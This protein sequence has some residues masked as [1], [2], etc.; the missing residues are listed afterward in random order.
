MF[1]KKNNQSFGMEERANKRKKRIKSITDRTDKLLIKYLP[2][3]FVEQPNISEIIYNLKISQLKEA[4]KSKF[5]TLSEYKYAHNLVSQFIN[6]GN[7]EGKWLL[8]VPPYLIRYKRES[9]LRTLK[10]FNN[11][12]L[13][14]L[15]NAKFKNAIF[16]NKEISTLS[17]DQILGV[18]LISAAING[19]LCIQSGLASLCQQLHD[20]Q[21]LFQQQADWFWIDLYY[22]S[23]H[24]V[25]Y[26]INDEDKSLRR[27]YPDSVTLSLIYF[28]LIKRKSGEIERES[29]AFTDVTCWNLIHPLLK[30]YYKPAS[31]KLLMSSFCKAAIGLVEQQDKV[32]LSQANLHHMIGIVASSSLTPQGQLSLFQSFNIKQSHYKFSDL[33]KIPQGRERATQKNIKHDKIV[34]FEHLIKKI[35]DAI[36]IYKDKRIKGGEFKLNTSSNA[37]KKLRNI[38]AIDLP[39]NVR[40]ITLWLFYLLDVKNLKI[41]TLRT[42]FSSIG[43]KWLS[44][45]VDVE[46]NLFDESDF[47]ELYES[48]LDVETSEKSKCYCSSRLR[49]FHIFAT[50]EL[51]F[52]ALSQ[53]LPYSKN[54]RTYVR[55]GFINELTFKLLLQSVSYIEDLQELTKQGLKC[56]LIIAY[57]AGLRRG[58]LIKLKFFD[59]EDSD[60][61]WVFIRNNK[62]GTNKSGSALRKIPLAV[63]LLDTEIEILDKYLAARRL[64]INAQTNALLFSM[65]AANEIPLEANKIS[66]MVKYLLKA[67]T[68]DLPFTFHHLR[69]SALSKLH[70][71]LEGDK[72]LISELTPYSFKQAN[73]IR[74]VLVNEDVDNNP[75]DIYWALAGV[76]GHTTPEVTFAHYLH[77]TDKIIANKVLKSSQKYSSKELMQL[78]GFSSNFFT[79]LCKN[80]KLDQESIDINHIRLDIIKGLKQYTETI[81]LQSE[82]TL[83]TSVLKAADIIIKPFEIK[84]TFTLCLSILFDAEQGMALSELVIKYQLSAELISKWVGNATELSGLI[85]S[86]NKS[87]LFSSLKSVPKNQIPLAPSKPQTNIELIDVDKVIE[88]IRVLHKTK[89]REI[90]FCIKYFIT[91]VTSSSSGITF[92][93]LSELKRFLTLVIK[94]FDK[95]RWRIQLNPLESLDEK[96]SQS[97]WEKVSNNIKVELL[98]DTIL[99]KNL[100][101]NGRVQLYLAHP[102]ERRLLEQSKK[103][104]IKS[105]KYSSN[106]L[107]YIFHG[108]AIYLFKNDE[109]QAFVKNSN[110]LN[111]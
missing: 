87:R 95:D 59:I 91:H 29:K 76:A 30:K 60:E 15:W 35:R 83:R 97:R 73:K 77:F 52:P 51:G 47:F 103:Y 28:Y 43:S 24:S 27:W 36:G 88:S 21:K 22:N 41:K 37:N 108:L 92:S 65:P 7:K 86:K 46:L 64:D 18:I 67:I 13:L 61:K 53:P 80:E 68:G 85:T 102:E 2:E 39:D 5:K 72:E 16:T 4:L 62:Y 82:N 11:V 96:K 75:R 12:K 10:W 66:A 109:C 50:R 78:S 105:E 48:M 42:Y 99:N 58:E 49:D 3:L 69:H 23:S 70:V 44:F 98:E 26:T 17:D 104:K 81:K 107:S 84:P 110:N 40:Y 54:G 31:K 8:D 19:G 20:R 63:L 100:Y 79:R 106:I 74:E 101:P 32:Q 111:L 89:P 6:N 33:V 45:T 55:A 93:N 25:N 1:T 57:R 34:E 38:L 71:V 14:N 94:F 90:E 56:L 9:P